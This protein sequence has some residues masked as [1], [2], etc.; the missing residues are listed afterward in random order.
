MHLL[1]DSVLRGECISD[2]RL[3][4]VSALVNLRLCVHKILVARRIRLDHGLARGKVGAAALMLLIHKLLRLLTLKA[5]QKHAI[6]CAIAVG[7][8]CRLHRWLLL[9]VLLELGGVAVLYQ[10][11]LA[12]RCHPLLRMLHG[13]DGI[14]RVSHPTIELRRRPLLQLLVLRLLLLF[15]FLLVFLELLLLDEV[16]VVVQRLVELELLH[17]FAVFELLVLGDAVRCQLLV[18]E[19]VLCGGLLLLRFSLVIRL[20]GLLADWILQPA[21]GDCF[22]ALARLLQR[23]ALDERLHLR[24][25]SGLPVGTGLRV[26]I[27]VR[28]AHHLVVEVAVLL[29][30][31]RCFCEF[32]VVSRR[33]VRQHEVREVVLVPERLRMVVC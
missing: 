3:A 23:G 30:I 15:L 4:H 21:R 26:G 18:E 2:L 17:L 14:A 12:E 22:L 33:A 6:V 25:T 5:R 10:I 29:L 20:G 13:A 8:S 9:R 32:W 31:K 28:R 16:G 7:S 24:E 19:I 1:V 11:L 27:Q